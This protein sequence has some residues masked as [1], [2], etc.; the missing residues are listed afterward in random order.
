MKANRKSNI[1]DSNDNTQQVGSKDICTYF[2]KRDPEDYEPAA[3][4]VGAVTRQAQAGTVS[5]LGGSYV[6][7]APDRSPFVFSITATM[8]QLMVASIISISPSASQVLVI[9]SSG[10]GTYVCSILSST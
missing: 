9:T 5:A 10:A 1:H 4:D 8:M 7:A 6:Q 2:P 3:M